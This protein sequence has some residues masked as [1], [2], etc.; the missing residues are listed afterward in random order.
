MTATVV[1]TS[2]NRKQDLATAVQSALDQTARP[3]VLVIDDGSTDGTSE[4]I[5]SRFPTVRLERS[6]QSAGLIVQRN[7]GAKLA[8]GDVIFSIDD[9]AIF[10]TPRVVEQTLAEFTAPRIGAIAIP[11][12]NVNQDQTVRQRAPADGRVHVTP[13]YIGTA[14]AVRRDVFVRLG[15]YREHLFHQGEEGDFCIRLL[16]AGYVVAIGRS[17]P[18]HHFESP[19]RDTRRMGLYG[20]RNDILFAWHNVPLT[21]LPGR[22]IRATAGGL[23]HGL[24]HGH[25]L[26][27]ARGL[28]W[29]YASMLRFFEQ[30]SPVPNETYRLQRQLIARGSIPLDEIEPRLPAMHT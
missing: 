21:G 29:G 6:E 23:S 24:K 7:R 2:K 18:I 13:S 15:G 3:E 12:I 26:Q 19:R 27:H 5:R 22:L 4:L 14:H 17:D 8:N 9:D 25:L 28:V 11:F 10:S 20:R 30:R 16:A 1:I